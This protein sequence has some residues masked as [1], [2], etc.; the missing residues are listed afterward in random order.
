M[1]DKKS[2]C[3]RCGNTLRS[4]NHSGICFRCEEGE[5]NSLSKLCILCNEKPRQIYSSGL[6]SSYCRECK[7]TTR[8]NTE[9]GIRNNKRCLVCN[10]IISHLADIEYCSDC[11]SKNIKKG[12]QLCRKCRQRERHI[13]YSGKMLTYCST[14]ISEYDRAKR[15]FPA[16]RYSKRKTSWL[17]RGIINIPTKEQYEKMLQEANGICP[18]CG[19][20]PINKKAGLALH[21]LHTTGEW[22]G[23]LCGHCNATLGY[24]D[25]S[26]ELLERLYDYA[27]KMGH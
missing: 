7:K 21:H 16:G 15:N 17:S 13:S 20:E 24:M 9:R 10:R 2:T 11:S 8:K 14:C 25:E 12:D 5:D 4:N 1:K 3:L 26:V 22:I 6:T 23:L 18:A 19:R 27:L